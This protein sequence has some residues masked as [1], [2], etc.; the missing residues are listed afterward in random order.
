M[1]Y[2][3]ETP[4]CSNCKDWYQIGDTEY[5]ACDAINDKNSGLSITVNGENVKSVLDG[6]IL[7]R[8]WNGY[9]EEFTKY[10]E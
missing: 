8:I 3:T 6:V 5:G 9:C 4:V 2:D 7:K 10:K 1:F